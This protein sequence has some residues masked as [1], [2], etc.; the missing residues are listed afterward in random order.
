[1]MLALEDPV[2]PAEMLLLAEMETGPE[3]VEV[4]EV[5]VVLS[6]VAL[7][8]RALTV[9]PLN[10]GRRLAACVLKKQFGPTEFW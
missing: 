6:I 8:R 1:M 4:V 2:G 10:E 9:V 3:A 7:R 5:A